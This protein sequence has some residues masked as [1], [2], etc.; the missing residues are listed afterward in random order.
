MNRP[1]R[2]TEGIWEIAADLFHTPTLEQSE[3]PSGGHSGRA[4]QGGYEVERQRLC[5]AFSL[6]TKQL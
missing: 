5:T 1:E 3:N 4:K 6:P 2:V